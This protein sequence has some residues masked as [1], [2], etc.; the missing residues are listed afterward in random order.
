MYEFLLFFSGIFSLSL[1]PYEQRSKT[2]LFGYVILWGIIFA[3]IAFRAEDIGA[4]TLNYLYKYLNINAAGSYNEYG[5][6][7]ATEPLFFLINKI[8]WPI[9]GSW[10]QCVFLLE[11]VFVVYA[12]GDAIWKY[13]KHPNLSTL[14]F[15]GLGLYLTSLCLL[16]QFLAM[17]I[18]VYSLKYVFERNPSKFYLCTLVAA[19]MHYSAIFWIIVYYICTIHKFS[20]KTIALFIVFAVVGY[21]YTGTLQEAASG[22][23]DRWE[24]YSN[25]ESEAG[26]D[27]S[28]TIF[29]LITLL[30]SIDYDKIVKNYNHGQEL[31]L[32][33][34]LNMI[35]WTMRLVTRNTER[36]SFY[37]VIAPILLIPIICDM[38]LKSNKND[39]LFHY[40]IVFFMLLFFYIKFTKDPILYPY[41]FCF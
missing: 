23:Y 3:T 35:L 7:A 24:G 32:L 29:A 12:Y 31:L 5:G 25:V 37:F 30:A 13:S 28:F 27:I 9:F 41:K 16:R 39:N 40:L 20:K 15:L 18:C 2:D 14:A 21:F 8:L 17:S 1:K 34:Y 10:N 11:A 33:N 26:G 38:R 4:D 19:L 36:I 22:V 6:T